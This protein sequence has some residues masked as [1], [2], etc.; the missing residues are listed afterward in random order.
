VGAFY[1]VK[2]RLSP[3]GRAFLEAREGVVGHWYRD[4]A[5]FWTAGMGHKWRSVELDG[6]EPQDGQPNLVTPE[7]IEAWLVADVAK[8]EEAINDCGVTVYSQNGFDAL[9]SLVF[10]I[11]VGAFMSST[12]L[13]VLKD[14]FHSDADIE[15]AWLMWDKDVQNGAKVVDPGLL[16]RRRLEVALYLTQD[17]PTP[18]VA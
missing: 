1:E 2:A 12:L 10:N 15:D 14:Q 11:G 13:R 9:V 7:Q 18:D 17:Q 3:S 16:A 8:C 5:R 4:V 6:P